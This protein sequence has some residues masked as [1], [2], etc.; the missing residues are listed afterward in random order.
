MV[1]TVKTID[2]NKLDYVRTVILSHHHRLTEDAFE[3]F[4][5]SDSLLQVSD[6]K[7]NSFMLSCYRTKN[8]DMPELFYSKAHDII[9]HFLIAI[10]VATLGHFTW[11]FR[12]ISP[13]P[14]QYVDVKKNEAHFLFAG[15][16]KYVSEEEELLQIEKPLI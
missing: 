11:D 14:Y 5:K 13:V 12:F 3:Y 4:K 15:T 9:S 10:N 6:V 1:V 16:Q 8:E 2:F 7:E